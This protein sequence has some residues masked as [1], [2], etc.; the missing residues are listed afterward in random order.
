V[1]NFRF[2]L[3]KV[4]NWQR[5]RRDMEELKLKQLIL[6]LDRAQGDLEQ[7]HAER[8]AARQQIA[9]SQALVGQD[10]AALEAYRLRLTKQ[11]LSLGKAIKECELQVAAQKQ[12]CIESE[13]RCRLFEKLKDRR[14]GEFQQALDRER[15]SFATE[16]HLARSVRENSQQIQ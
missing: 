2:N 8:A 11:E 4:L 7:L 3:E 6:A 5:V 16:M 9:S 14:F 1:E 13:R 15:E 12:R 10:V